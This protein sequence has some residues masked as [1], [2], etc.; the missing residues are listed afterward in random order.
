MK[1]KRYA[2]WR[3]T[4]LLRRWYLT[5]LLYDT[6]E[7]AARGVPDGTVVELEVEVPDGEQA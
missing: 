3:K 4:P 5:G 7:E 2:V 1:V 6:R